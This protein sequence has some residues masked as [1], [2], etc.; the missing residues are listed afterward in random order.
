MKYVYVVSAGKIIGKGADVEWDLS[1][2]KPGS[3]TITA[4]ISQPIFDG[5]RW[6]VL[7]RTRT[8][9]LVIKE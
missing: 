8:K 1:D 5:T 7:G 2:A 4:G 6:E 3:Y 9:V